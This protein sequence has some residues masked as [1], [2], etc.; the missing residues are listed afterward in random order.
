MAWNNLLGSGTS[1]LGIMGVSIFIG[2]ILDKTKT[3]FVMVAF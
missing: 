2:Y 1:I 3:L